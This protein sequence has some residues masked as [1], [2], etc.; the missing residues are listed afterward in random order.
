MYAYHMK[1]AIYARVST[2]DQNCEAQLT[3][4]REYAERRG[5]KVV[6]VYVDEG[7]SGKKA[8]RPALNRLMADAA[9]RRFDA[10][11]CWKLDR[12]ARSALHLHQNLELLASYGIMFNAVS[13]GI[14][15]DAANPVAKLLITVL[16]AIA[17]F[18]SSLI[19]ER[20]AIGVARARAEGK[21]IGRPARVFKRDE[22]V[23]LRDSEGLSWRAIAKRMNLPVTTVVEAYQRYKEAA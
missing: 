12:F 16:G 6:D 1:V 15:T 17:E 22:V 11:A 14:T 18:E 23:R 7:F 4:L 8:S 13:Q 2:S 10:V 3:E 9:K 21:S 19:K 20:T 5:W